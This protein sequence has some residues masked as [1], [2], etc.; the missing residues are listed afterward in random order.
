[1]Q[2]HTTNNNPKQDI[3][4]NSQDILHVSKQCKLSK[5]PKGKREILV[6]KFRELKNESNISLNLPTS[7]GA[8][9][10]SLLNPQHF[11]PP[12]PPSYHEV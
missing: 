10:Q 3:D 2:Q 7:E 12:L 1:M 9:L 11:L 4:V 5:N 6:S 8:K